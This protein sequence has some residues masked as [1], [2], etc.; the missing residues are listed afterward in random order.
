MIPQI[1]TLDLDGAP[2]G[3]SFGSTTRAACGRT[4][5]RSTEAASRTTSDRATD[6]GRFSVH[7]GEAEND[8]DARMGSIHD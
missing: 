4:F 2:C 8:Q 6:P 5:S 7:R 1:L 3:L